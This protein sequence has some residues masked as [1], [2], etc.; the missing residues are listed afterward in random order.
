MI[1][2]E[3]KRSKIIKPVKLQKV[4]EANKVYFS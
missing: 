4:K 3:V 2:N 1:N